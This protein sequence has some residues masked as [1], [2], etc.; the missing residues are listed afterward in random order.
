MAEGDVERF[1]FQAEINQLLSLIINTFYSNKEIFLRELISNASDALDKIRFEG[2]TDKSKLESQ[3]EL[4][5]HIIPDKAS[6]TLT[7]IDSGIGMTKSDLVNNLGTIA[8]SGTKEFMEA[9]AAGADVS[10]IGQFGVGFYSAYLVAE[11]VVVT[12]KHNDDEQYIWESEA[13]GSFTVTRDTT[14]ERLG[15]GTKIVLYLKEDQLEYLEERRLKDLIKKHSEFISYPISVWV[16]KT[17]EKEISDDE[18]E[19]EKKDDEEGKIEEVDEDKEKEK[20]KKKTVK[21]VSHEWS[22]VNTQKPIWMRKPDEITKE[23]YGA[24]YKSLTNDWEDHLAVK[25]FAVEGQLEFRA[26]LFVPKRAPFDLF[27]TRKKLNN[28]K[29]YVRRVF[30]MD[31]CEEI[32]PEYLAF[33]KG[34]VD[35]NDLPLNISREMLQ[36]NKILKVIRK[37]LVKKCLEMFAEIAENKEDYNKFYESFSKN[38]K[39]GIHEDSQ[40]RQKLADLL[41]YHST[42]SGDEMTSLKDYVT[43]MKEGQKDIFYITG[44]SKKAVEN[45]PFLERLKRKGYE[46]LYMVDAIDEYAVGQLKEYDGKK[47]VSA[48]KEG[49]KLEDTDDEKK[50]FEEKK[51][52]FEGLCKVIKDILGEKVEKVVVSDRIVDSPCCLV[53]GE[54]GWTANMERIMKAQAL[55]DSSMSSYM[56]SKKTMEIN[57]DNS[58]ME[59]LRKRADA[60]KNDKAVKDLVLLLFETALLTSGFS[61]DDPNTFGSRIHRMLKLGLS[62]DDDVGAGAD[63]DVDMPPLEEGADAEGSKMEEVD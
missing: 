1:A 35:S 16:E 31:N 23:E 41:R 18:E 17:T 26:I 58:I 15:R 27:D 11:K 4:F 55:R 62:I 43:R 47:L 56:S 51:A 39:L 60:D 3:P 10:M 24:F 53:T 45:S 44:E 36:Q 42:K 63:A 46:V 49:L 2:L 30:I 52:A 6:K 8:R 33:V 29:L 7:I 12:T 40:N 9:L 22:L 57:P 14:G 5:I 32:I 54:Y 34:V 20:K 13:G 38:I 59:E 37:N 19:E 25:H 28:I 21:E 48:T 61:L 50:K